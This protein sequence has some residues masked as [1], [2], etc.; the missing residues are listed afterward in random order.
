VQGGQNA[1][2]SISRHGSR[3]LSEIDS[4]VTSRM[5]DQASRTGGFFQ[6]L[7]LAVVD[8]C[9]PARDTRMMKYDI[10]QSVPSLES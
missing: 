1:G 8:D 6:L 4:V 9:H 7:Y 10:F 5:K 3:D 2:N